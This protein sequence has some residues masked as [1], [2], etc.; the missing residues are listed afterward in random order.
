MRITVLTYVEKEGLADYD[1]VVDQVADALRESGHEVSVLPIYSDVRRLVDGLEQ[2]KPELVF[3]LM[4]MFGEN[5]YG[6]IDVVG[7][8]ELL[9]VRYT[10]CGP[11]AFFL[12]QD[13]AV[14]KRLLAFEGI[15]CPKF[16]VFTKEDEELPARGDLRLP[17]FVKPVRA[18]A[19]I[20][21][22][23]KSLVHDTRRMRRRVTRI[24]KRFRDE[25]MVEEYIE[26]RE[27]YVG[28]LG[29]RKAIALPPIEMDFSGLPEGTP[30]FLDRNAKFGEG[31]AEF[32][33]TKAKVAEIDDAL[34]DKLQS[35]S[36]AAYRALKV[37]D[38]GR[39]D[40][41]LTDSGEL[42]VLEVNAS[43]YLEKN[44]EFSQAAAAAGMSYPTLVCRIVEL[45]VERYQNA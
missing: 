12:A 1:G 22:D 3:N 34:R 13:K 36:V 35:I 24:H 10:G 40:L 37:R 26:G 44:S 8:L 20:G 41:R 2:N 17:L 5:L 32:E 9:N 23:S 31:T 11:G 45:A 28:V 30:R 18:D 19:S 25:A 43:C 33:G 42:Y 38:Y 4:E 39:V 21:I 6:D 29:N 14:A 7:L 27:F 15:Q 16:I